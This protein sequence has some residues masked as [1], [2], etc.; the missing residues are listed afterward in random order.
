MTCNYM[1]KGFD[2]GWLHLNVF[3][4]ENGFM[5]SEECTPYK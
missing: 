3:F 2:K 1:N 4:T 5:N